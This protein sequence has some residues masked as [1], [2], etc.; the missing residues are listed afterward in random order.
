VAG[1]FF[2]LQ[3]NPGTCRSII[4]ADSDSVFLEDPNQFAG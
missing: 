1:L 2:A 3:L 4:D